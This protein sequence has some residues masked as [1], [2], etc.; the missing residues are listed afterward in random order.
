[1]DVKALIGRT[2]INNKNGRIVV[3]KEVIPAPFV[4]D[5]LVR[6]RTTDGIMGVMHLDGFTVRYVLA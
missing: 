4:E 1:M 6:Y 3:L 2:F 5:T